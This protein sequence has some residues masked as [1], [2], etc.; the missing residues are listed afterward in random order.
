L[1]HNNNN[2]CRAFLSSF[3]LNSF[4]NY[5]FRL[6]IVLI[7]KLEIPCQGYFFKIAKKRQLINLFFLFPRLKRELFF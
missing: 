2:N 3:I 4:D 5:Q 6:L 7:I 1:L